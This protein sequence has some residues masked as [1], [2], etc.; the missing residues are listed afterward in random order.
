MEPF[1]IYG[2]DLDKD[3]MS[4]LHQS[5]TSDE[6]VRWAKGYCAKENM[7]GW[8]KVSVLYRH[9]PTLTENT[10]W[11]CYNEPMPWSDNAYEEF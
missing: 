9:L 7:G 4:L 2:Y 1:Y 11:S 8:G 10:I 6:A 5:W 3:D